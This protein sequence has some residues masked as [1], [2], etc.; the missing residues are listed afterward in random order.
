M[1]KFATSMRRP[2]DVFLPNWDLGGSA[3]LDFAISSG[4]GGVNLRA[5]ASDGGYSSVS[6][7]AFKRH[8]LRTEAQLQEIG[9]QFIPMVMEKHGGSWGPSAL[10][11]WKKVAK[12]G[13]ADL[14]DTAER[15]MSQFL[16][17]TSL[18]LHKE[19]ARSIWRR[20]AGV[21]LLRTSFAEFGY[22]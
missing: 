7:E 18:I 19:T 1:R 13:A 2:A 20:E 16:Q 15:E 22:V 3:A 14:G 10:A 12:M 5:S 17:S 8:H 6:Y 11:F 9:I 21:P 4:L